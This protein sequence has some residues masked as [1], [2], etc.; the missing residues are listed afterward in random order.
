MKIPGTYLGFI[1]KIPH[2]VQLGVNAVELLP[3]HEFFVDDFLIAQGLTNYWGYNSIGF[4]APESSYR[5]GQDARLPG[6]RV[7]DAGPR[8]AQR[9]A[10]R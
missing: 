6:H 7:Q 9:R 1:E 10:S 4:F 5:T 2:L 3:V 8:A